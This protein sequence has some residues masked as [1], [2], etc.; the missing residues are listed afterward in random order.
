[1]ASETHQELRR[2]LEGIHFAANK[3]DLVSIAMS[4]GAPEDLIEQLEDL[5]RK[6]FSDF[7]EVVEAV[8]DLRPA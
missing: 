1:M 8:D 6:E 5:P 2:H 7:E 4:N 3:E